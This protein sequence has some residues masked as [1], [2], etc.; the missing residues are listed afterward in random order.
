MNVLLLAALLAA[1]VE[2]ITTDTPLPPPRAAHIERIQSTPEHEEPTEQLLA[3]AALFPVA[4][5]AQALANG[6]AI[7]VRP[8]LAE[9]PRLD[10]LAGAIDRHYDHHTPGAIVLTMRSAWPADPLFAQARKNNIRILEID[11]SRP[12]DDSGPGIALQSS[13]PQDGY[14][15]LSLNNLSRMAEIISR[16][17]TRL[18]P[19]QADTFTA[20]LNQVKKDLFALQSEV[21]KATLEIDD[22]YVSATTP[23]FSYL[24]E[25]AGFFTEELLAG[26]EERL[27]WK[28]KKIDENKNFRRKKPLITDA[29][30][31]PIDPITLGEA[32]IWEII[33]LDPLA[34]IPPDV[35]THT[36][37]QQFTA[38]YRANLERL[39]R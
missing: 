9:Y 4:A 37:W 29:S 12:L 36:L 34:S 30:H 21:A 31:P 24:L 13:V 14:P 35:P 7:A 22:P 39:Y 18:V 20:N 38:Q 2:R 8:I 1:S 19:G 3:D 16:D 23:A 11:A 5:L 15:W 10:R 27:D 17:F 26:A 6:T 28:L 33:A 32:T 25:S